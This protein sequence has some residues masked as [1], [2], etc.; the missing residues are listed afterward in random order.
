MVLINLFIGQ[1]W[2]HKHREQTHGHGQRVGRRG[3]DEWREE[4]GSIYTTVCEKGNQGE[5]AVWFSELN[6]GLYNSL[7]GWEVWEVRGRLERRGTCLP[8]AD[9]C[10]CMTEAN[11][12][13]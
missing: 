1:Q 7:K 10:C 9:S 12:I 5:F 2:R 3:W 11:T 6:P 8:M 4:H 13:L